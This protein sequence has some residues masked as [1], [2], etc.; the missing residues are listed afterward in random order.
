MVSP[1]TMEWYLSCGDTIAAWKSIECGIGMPKFIP[2]MSSSLRFV[3]TNLMRSPTRARTVGP[4]TPSP[5]AQAENFT[6]GARSMTLFVTS[7]RTSLT[8][9]AS[10]LGIVGSCAAAVPMPVGAGRPW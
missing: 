6:P 4:G 8:G 7:R 3:I 5:N 10:S 9:P 2:L 1:G